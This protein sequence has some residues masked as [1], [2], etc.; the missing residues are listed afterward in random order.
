MIK[1]ILKN[2]NYISNTS[3]FTLT[4]VLVGVL[5]LS[6]SIVAAANF[7]VSMIHS[8]SAN[9]SHLQAYYYSQEGLEAFRNMRDTHF[10]N[11]LD[12]CGKG[13]GGL[14]GIQD[15]F[16]DGCV[17]NSSSVGEVVGYDRISGESDGRAN[18][19][20]GEDGRI[21][22]DVGV[23]ATGVSSYVVNLDA[24]PSGGVDSKDGMNAA[25][26]WILKSGGSGGG[27][28]GV[29]FQKS[30]TESIPTDFKRICIVESFAVDT[31]MSG[32]FEGGSPDS[33]GDLGSTDVGKYDGKA[34]KVTCTTSWGEGPDEK[35]VSLSTV[36]TNWKHE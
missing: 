6:M 16:F 11:N 8:N 23:G 25:A 3:G 13:S 1:K 19:S 30:L 20:V 26:S 31:S 12:F 17:A 5:V 22:R 27:D 21:N 14:W 33:L 9:T 24:N 7:L 15:G 29:K 4:E 28:D 34:I 18:R 36:L 35:S 10:M 2:S 32:S